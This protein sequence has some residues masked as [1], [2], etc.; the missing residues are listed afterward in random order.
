MPGTQIRHLCDTPD[1]PQE[2]V[3][4]E[5][6]RLTRDLP[7]E[8]KAGDGENNGDTES[9]DEG[10]KKKTPNHSRM[11]KSRLQKLVDKTDDECI[12]SRTSTGYH[13]LTSI[14]S[15]TGYL[16]GIHGAPQQ[17]IV[18]RLL[19]GDQEAS[20][21]REYFCTCFPLPTANTISPLHF[22]KS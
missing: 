13:V 5:Y 11:L 2:P 10:G 21:S 22:R 17:E 12:S 19:Q 7:V 4:R 8:A 14:L 1:L 16:C 3:N 20:V 9:G 18:A 15:W 6:A